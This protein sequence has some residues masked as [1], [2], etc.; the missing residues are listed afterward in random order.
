MFVSP[1]VF[2]GCG[3]RFASAPPGSPPSIRSSHTLSSRLLCLQDYET[4]RNSVGVLHATWEEAASELDQCRLSQRR[5][6]DEERRREA[7][8]RAYERGDYF[9]G[10]SS[11]SGGR[12][13]GGSRHGLFNDSD[14]DRDDHDPFKFFSGEGEGGRG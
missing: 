13:G 3:A 9:H 5:A 7:E 14:D 1:T 10:S 11:R 12:G 2:H 4:Y 8:A 6:N